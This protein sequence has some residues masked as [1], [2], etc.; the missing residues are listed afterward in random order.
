MLVFKFNSK[1]VNCEKFTK[2]KLFDDINFKEEK[3]FYIKSFQ[4]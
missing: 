4:K 3:V 1:N 2:K